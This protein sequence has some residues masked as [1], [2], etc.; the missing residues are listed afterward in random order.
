VVWAASISA[1][2]SVL[3][4]APYILPVLPILLGGAVIFIIV[5]MA[6]RLPPTPPRQ[7]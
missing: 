3:K 5:P 6:F 2:S 7:G 4:G 1:V